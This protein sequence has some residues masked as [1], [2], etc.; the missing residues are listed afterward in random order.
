MAVFDALVYFGVSLEDLLQGIASNDH[1]ME[2]DRASQTVVP[3]LRR[4]VSAEFDHIV[5][6]LL[7]KGA[8]EVVVQELPQHVSLLHVVQADAG[9]HEVPDGPLIFW[10]LRSVG[11]VGLGMF[12]RLQDVTTCYR[13][14][15]E[16]RRRRGWD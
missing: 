15:G 6:V 3:L 16:A 9:P 8:D 10:V 4:Q 1:I 11:I 13:Q 12:G 2:N 14:V 7:L 5:G